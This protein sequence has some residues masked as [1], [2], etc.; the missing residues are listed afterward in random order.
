MTDAEIQPLLQDFTECNLPKIV[1]EREFA[2]ALVKSADPMFLLKIPEPFRSAIVRFGLNTTSLWQEVSSG[3]LADYS[4][5]APALHT[6]VLQF[7]NQVAVGQYIHWG[8]G[9]NQ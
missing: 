2:L 9:S 7:K 6:L 1:V 4:Q 3:G 8:S 5:H